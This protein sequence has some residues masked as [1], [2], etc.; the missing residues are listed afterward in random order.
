MKF[1]T[2]ALL[3]AALLLVVRGAAAQNYY[4][5]TGG[6]NSNNG[7]SP[8][9][10]WRDITYA[11]GAI[12]QSPGAAAGITVH[13]APGTYSSTVMINS[14]ASGTASSRLVYLS[15]QRWG[16]KIVTSNDAP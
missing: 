13:V 10:A 14:S 11:V 2:T 15:D 7:T 16:A 1:R 3:L 4:V 5:S 9:T 6:S 12:P 8:S